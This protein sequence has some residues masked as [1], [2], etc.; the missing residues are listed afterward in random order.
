MERTVPT[1]ASEA[2]DLYLRT[3]Y[4]LLRTTA[5]VQ[6]RTLEE[7]HSAMHSLLHPDAR[8]SSPDMS[9]FIY[10]L[11]RLPAC[12]FKVDLVV[13]GQGEE[14]FVQAGLGEVETWQRAVAPARRRRC[15][16]DGGD[17]LACYIA[18][19]TDIDDLIPLLAA[20]QIEWNKM[21]LLMT[22]TAGDPLLLLDQPG[23]ALA[24]QLEDSK[25]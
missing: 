23:A 19:R 16:F 25:G 4:S 14:D 1:T 12:I 13:M 11:L 2:I 15:F 8:K 10:C 6:I 21:H 22:H 3:F 9:A 17:T 7:S 5:E 24:E 20:F 18:S